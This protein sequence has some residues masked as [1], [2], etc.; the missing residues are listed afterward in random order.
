M[1]NFL[2]F[3][4]ITISSIT[5][6]QKG[7]QEI[8]IDVG[9]AIIMRSLELTYEYNVLEQSSVGLSAFINFA[10][11]SSK[12]RY[13][14]KT[15]FTPFFRHYFTDSRKWNYF[16]EV[17]FGINSG[18]KD[19]NY[20]DLALG[21]SGGLK[22]ISNGGVTISGLAGVGR[23]LFTDKAKLPVVLRFGVCV[24]YRF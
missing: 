9:D 15:M 24:G 11:E 13:Q 20:T 14:E 3:L 23:N 10:K 6:A 18:Y 19:E 16:G 21:V 12:F 4:V 7:M 17:F 5:Y 2:L 8:N 22:Y 1:K